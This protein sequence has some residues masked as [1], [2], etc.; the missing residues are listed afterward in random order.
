MGGT[1]PDDLK[2]LRAL[3]EGVVARNDELEK[4]VAE[5]DRLIALQAERIAELE[6]RQRRDSS[7]SSRP[8]S[9][10]A[11]W[12]KRRR[13]R[14]PPSEKSQGAQ[15][16]HAG[17]ARELKDEK[18]VDEI[19][20]HEP[21]QC[22]RC[23]GTD[24]MPAARKPHRRQVTEIPPL[25]ARTT[26]HRLHH[27]H[28]RDCGERVT[29]ALPAD[30]PSG[31]FGAR[32]QALIVTLTGNYRVSRR[33][34]ARLLGDAFGISISPGSVSNVEGRMSRA[35]DLPHTE[36]LGALRK[37]T[38]L[39]VDETPWSL[40][41][42]LH[43]LWTGVADGVVVHRI[44]R[45]RNQ[46]ALTRLIGKLCKA[47]VVSDRMGA[48]DMLADKRRQL[49]WAHLERDFRARAEGRRG[50][51]RFGR[52]GLRIAQALMRAAREYRVHGDRER[53]ER[54]LRPSLGRLILLLA[55]GADSKHRRVRGM[56]LHL[57]DRADAL[58]TFADVPG[59]PLTNNAAERAV[60][61]PVLLRKNSFGSQSERGLRFVERILTVDA[62][63]RRRS[64]GVFDYLV[65]VARAA[66]AGRPTP[67]LFSSTPGA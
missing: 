53:F 27:A 22:S 44:D 3:V 39:N 60:R 10:D 45:R 37:S 2:D 9:S 49:C 33:E 67:S 47:I 65:E 26:E 34:T 64:Q 62:T 31:A 21:E 4:R 57:L 38:V 17:K 20:D 46:A 1:D 25:I 66:I 58:W 52:K 5:Q 23:G 59:V 32:L 11:P 56:A 13:R 54:E 29:A 48:Y 63:R 55:K 6:T 36:A 18:D 42:L 61:K 19:V 12:S 35:L 51:R 40:G 14:R 50:G 16:G 15:P 30:V 8:P 41:G 24:L 43:W 28:C 7:N